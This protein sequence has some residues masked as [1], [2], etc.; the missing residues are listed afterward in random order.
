MVAFPKDIV[1][2]EPTITMLADRSIAM[3]D[4]AHAIPVVRIIFVVG[5]VAG[6]AIT[7]GGF[8]R[9]ALRRSGL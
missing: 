5:L 2:I 6:R 4:C 9:R 3:L 7:A 8:V 1:G